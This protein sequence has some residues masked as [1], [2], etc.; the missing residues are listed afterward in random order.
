MKLQ[1]YIAVSSGGRL[2]ACDWCG[3]WFEAGGS[4][5][6]SDAKFC[7]SGCRVQFHRQK[8]GGSK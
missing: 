7:S 3:T 5:K 4:G 8:N 6:R 1:L 2:K